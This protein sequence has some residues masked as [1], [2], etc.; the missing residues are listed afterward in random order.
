MQEASVLQ[1]SATLPKIDIFHGLTQANMS[2]LHGWLQP[3][4]YSAGVEIFHE[5]HLPTALYILTKGTAGVLSNSTE[6][7]VRLANIEAPCFF[8]EMALLEGGDRSA[9]IIAQTELAA[10]ILPADLFSA[11]LADNNL[12]AL[13]IA[14]NI[15]RLVCSRL[16]NQNKK[17]TMFIS[18]V[19]A[20]NRR[21]RRQPFRP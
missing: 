16:R 14:L 9:T 11:K 10:Y 17:V 5:G 12:T 7:R 19:A 6:G 8:G 15:G 4:V 20:H 1:K 2:E 3:R 18:N 13:K 21:I